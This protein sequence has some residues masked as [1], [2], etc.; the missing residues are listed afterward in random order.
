MIIGNNNKLGKGLGA[1]LGEKTTND[2]TGEK[3]EQISLN[4]I[5]PNPYQPRKTFD[6]TE[7]NNL[8]LSIKQSGVLQAIIV[9]KKDN[10]YEIVAGER[11]FRASKIAALKTIP[12]V[13]KNFDDKQILA[14]AIIENVQRSDLNIIDEAESYKKLIDELEY[15]QDEIADVVNKNRATI[16]NILRILKLPEEIKNMLREKQIELGHAKVL[17]SCD[18]DKVAIDI[19]NSVIDRDLSVRATEIL[20]K[21]S[22][23]VKIIKP[24]TKKEYL[25]NFEKDLTNKINL[26]T[27][28]EYNKEKNK[29]K[30]IIE[31]NNMQELEKFIKNI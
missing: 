18:D 31:Y 4:D 16:T 10:V 28:I 19:A 17:L 5:V 26:K 23:N 22:K 7:L 6:E 14:L 21:N 25:K 3:I 27:K 12:A 2:W 13:V 9:R 24:T 15:K 30:I 20:V 8:A 11:R 1:L 29:G